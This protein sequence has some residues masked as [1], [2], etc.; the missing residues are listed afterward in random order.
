MDFSR[1]IGCHGKAWGHHWRKLTLA[2]YLLAFTNALGFTFTFLEPETN[3]KSLEEL[4]GETDGVEEKDKELKAMPTISLSGVPIMVKITAIMIA[5]MDFFTDAYDLICIM[6][7]T[8]LMGRTYVPRALPIELTSAITRLALCGTLLGQVFFGYM[9]DKLGRKKVYGATLV[10]MIFLSIAS[11]LSFGKSREVVITSLC[12]FRFL[13]GFGTGGDYPLSATIM[14]EYANK[15]TRKWF[16]AAAFVMQGFGILAGGLV[17]LIVSAALQKYVKDVPLDNV[18]HQ[19]D[20]DYTPRLTPPGH[21]VHL[22]AP[23]HR[24][25]QPKSISKGHVQ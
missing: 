16:L 19:A 10:L 5:G 3:G 2:L 13:L 4:F 8:K 12:L 11:A 6:T 9:G 18:V 1:H 17:S 23:G 14:S 20:Y 24:F 21:D 25:L 7:I 22:V 15:K